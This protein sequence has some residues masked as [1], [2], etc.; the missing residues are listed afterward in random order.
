MPSIGAQKI[1]FTRLYVLVKTIASILLKFAQQF[2]LKVASV[3]QAT[4]DCISQMAPV[5][6]SLIVLSTKL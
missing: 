6:L 2:A 5:F 1:K 4:L 3:N